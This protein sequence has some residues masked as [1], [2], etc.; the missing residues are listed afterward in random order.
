MPIIPSPLLPP[1]CHSRRSRIRGAAV[2]D[3]HPLRD[4]GG[5]GYQRQ[6]LPP[7]QLLCGQGALEHG[8]LGC[9]GGGVPGGGGY[10]SHG[11]PPLHL[12]CGRG[13]LG[14]SGRGRGGAGMEAGG[15]LPQSPRYT[16]H[17]QPA[18]R[19]CAGPFGGAGERY[20]TKCV[21]VEG[22]GGAH[23]PS[24]DITPRSAPLSVPPGRL[25]ACLPACSNDPGGPPPLPPPLKI[26]EHRRHCTDDDV[27]AVVERV[28]SLESSGLIPPWQVNSTRCLSVHNPRLYL[29]RP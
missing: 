26:V 12:L 17:H 4:Q 27:R 22:G 8:C 28:H 13:A 2:Q 10:Q 3:P 9:V 7:I 21:C 6:G 1:S 24:G 20:D 5:G 11:L 29:P 18:R 16:T 23:C 25:P 19:R 14:P 15:I